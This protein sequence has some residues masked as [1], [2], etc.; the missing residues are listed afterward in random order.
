MNGRS[1]DRHHQFKM[2]G[3]TTFTYSAQLMAV[4]TGF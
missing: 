3:Q 4:L 2:I 1:K